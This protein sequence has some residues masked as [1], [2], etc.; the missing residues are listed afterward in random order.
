MI[1]GLFHHIKAPTKNK[2]DSDEYTKILKDHVIDFLYIHEPFQQDNAPVHTSGK[3]V[4]FTGKLACTV[5][6]LNIIKN[7]KSVQKKNI[8]KRHLET[9][10]ELWSSAQE[11]FEKSPVEYIVKLYDSIP[12]RLQLVVAKGDYP[13]KY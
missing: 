1:V 6:F 10:K 3:W 12:R 13:T 2:V 5:P 9:L 7:L 4:H 8:C 11:E